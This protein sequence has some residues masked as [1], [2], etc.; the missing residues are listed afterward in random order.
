M[1]IS[2]SKYDEDYFKIYEYYNWYQVYVEGSEEEMLAVDTWIESQF[3]NFDRI[4]NFH[5]GRTNAAFD[6]KN[7]DDVAMFKLRWL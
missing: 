7:E 4:I 2:I 6:I 1:R 3:S 5:T